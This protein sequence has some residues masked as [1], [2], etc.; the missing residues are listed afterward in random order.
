MYKIINT[1]FSYVRYDVLEVPFLTTTIQLGYTKGLFVN[2]F[3]IR[4]SLH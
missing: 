4:Q 1:F 2:L 3:K